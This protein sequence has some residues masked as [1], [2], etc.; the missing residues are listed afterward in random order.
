MTTMTISYHAKDVDE[1]AVGTQLYSR[2]LGKSGRAF[3]ILGFAGPIIGVA[4]LVHVFTD[5]DMLRPEVLVLVYALSA[6]I[7]SWVFTSAYF[8]KRLRRL[9]D[10]ASYR[11][12]QTTWHISPE[13][14][15][16]SP[17]YRLEWV[18][19]T[20]VHHFNKMTVLD[21]SVRRAV[22]VPDSALPAG[23]TPTDFANH[24]NTLAKV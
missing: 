10:Q 17:E 6:G 18:D 8:S 3:L 24:I 13:G 22:I 19:L 16:Q 23:M 7:I 15:F 9:V 14:C 12:T 4:T 11:D 20:A 1:V 2:F 21:F 5:L